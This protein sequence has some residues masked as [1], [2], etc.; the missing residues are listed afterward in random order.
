MAKKISKF[1][2]CLDPHFEPMYLKKADP[3]TF[4]FWVNNIFAMKQVLFENCGPMQSQQSG[5]QDG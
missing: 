1:Q 5:Y 4:S 2:K 3:D